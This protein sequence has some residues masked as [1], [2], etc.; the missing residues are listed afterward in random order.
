MRAMARGLGCI[1]VGT[2]L[3][4]WWTGVVPLGLGL[5][6]T[7]WAALDL[8]PGALAKVN[9]MSLKAVLFWPVLAYATAFLLQGAILIAYPYAV[10]LQGLIEAARGAA[11]LGF[12]AWIWT[13][14]PLASAIGVANVHEFIERMSMFD[15]TPPLP[16]EPIATIVV[17]SVGFTALGLIGRGL[18][19][20]AFGG[21]Q[22]YAYAPPHGL[23]NSAR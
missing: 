17:L 10:R 14:S 13:A 3:V 6:V 1:A 12:C 11:L 21:P 22:D 15:Q 18:W 5:D 23:S 4:L 16:L 2:V 19:N 8:D 20:L 7:D 9:W